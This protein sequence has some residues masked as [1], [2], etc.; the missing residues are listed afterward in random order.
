MQKN[1]WEKPDI[2]ASSEVFRLLTE[3]LSR[4]HSSV[5][6]S[7]PTTD[8]Q[9][10]RRCSGCQ[11]SC[12]KLCLHGKSVRKIGFL[13]NMCHSAPLDFL[14]FAEE[15]GTHID[16]AHPRQVAD[17]T[18]PRDSLKAHAATSQYSLDSTSTCLSLLQI[19]RNERRTLNKL[20]VL[21]RVA[22]ESPSAGRK[23]EDVAVLVRSA[24]ALLQALLLKLRHRCLTQLSP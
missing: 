11:I 16:N 12:K 20:A 7:K 17:T 23:A 1:I 3:L 15:H 10:P 22:L 21:D 4:S 5:Q 18:L 8:S 19:C 24:L 14:C 6:G 2:L 9:C 13:C